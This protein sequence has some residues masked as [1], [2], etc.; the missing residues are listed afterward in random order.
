MNKK[1]LG[2]GISKGLAKDPSGASGLRVTIDRLFYDE[3]GQIIVSALFGLALALLFR[4]ICKDNCVLYS[5]PDIKDIEGNIFNLEN[6]CYK[7]KSY[8]VKCNSI[9]KP[10]DPYDINKTPDNLISSPGFFEKMFFTPT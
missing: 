2:K 8:P 6:T 3:T 1:G 5:A 9:D 7:Y 10:L 4:R